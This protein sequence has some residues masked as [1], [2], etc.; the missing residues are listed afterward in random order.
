MVTND[1]NFY[2]ALVHLSNTDKILGKV[3]KEIKPEEPEKR[4]PN[5]E[6]LVRIITGQQ[7]LS[8]AAS[9]IFNRLK[10]LLS[11]K[12]I[13]PLLIKAFKPQQI[14]KCGLSNAK[15]KYIQNLAD[16]FL[17]QPSYLD[18]LKNKESKNI[19]EGFRRS[20]TPGPLM[21][22]SESDALDAEVQGLKDKLKQKNLFNINKFLLCSNLLDQWKIIN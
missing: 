2:E 12:K 21:T 7:L 16:L 18:E 5:F 22:K 17:E 11:K 9:T 6:S 1:F 14:L 13:T 4:E 15:T 10:E 3:I 19:I 20:K 8:A